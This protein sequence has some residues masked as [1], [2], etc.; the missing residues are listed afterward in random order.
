MTLKRITS[1]EEL[2]DYVVNLYTQYSKE[3]KSEKSDFIS[4][5]YLQDFL[6]HLILIQRYASKDD[7]GEERAKGSSNVS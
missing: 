5:Y 2:L 3:F 1:K 6:K 4:R 7:D